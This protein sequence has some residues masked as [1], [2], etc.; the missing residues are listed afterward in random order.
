M[1]SADFSN[2]NESPGIKNRNLLNHLSSP[3]RAS[4]V[5]KKAPSVNMGNNVGYRNKKLLSSSS[6]LSRLRD[7]RN[8]YGRK[9]NDEL[10]I[11]YFSKIPDIVE[12]PITV[13]NNVLYSKA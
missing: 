11:N 8:P 7:A 1:N 4:H 13:V 10:N 12:L 5:L 3:N 2:L 9:E 6:N